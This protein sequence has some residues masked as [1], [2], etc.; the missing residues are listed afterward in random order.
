MYIHDTHTHVHVPPGVVW[1]EESDVAGGAIIL[2]SCHYYMQYYATIINTSIYKLTS[3]RCW[4]CVIECSYTACCAESDITS[5]Y[6]HSCIIIHCGVI[7]F[8]ESKGSSNVG[9]VRH[10]TRIKCDAISSI[11][12][13]TG[14]NESDGTICYCTTCTTTV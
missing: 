14:A 8:I 11:L 7:E 2:K 3:R 13:G 9:A 1:D 6:Q 4:C 5:I 10:I 12:N